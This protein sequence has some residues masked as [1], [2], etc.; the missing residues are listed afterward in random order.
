MKRKITALLAVLLCF[1]VNTATVCAVYAP[2]D[3]LSPEVIE[4]MVH[5]TD[6]ISVSIWYKDD[7]KPGLT[8]EEAEKLYAAMAEE[9]GLEPLSYHYGVNDPVIGTKLTPEQILKIAEDDQVTAITFDRIESAVAFPTAHPAESKMDDA[10]WEA[11]DSGQEELYVHIK[12][13]NADQTVISEQA[14]EDAEILRESLD[15]EKYTL[16][17]INTIVANFQLRKKR[18]GLQKYV[19]DTARQIAE[20][21]GLAEGSYTHGT[22]LPTLSATLTPEQVRQAEAMGIVVGMT[23]HVDQPEDFSVPPTE[24]VEGMDEQTP[25]PTDVDV[26]QDPTEPTTEL[27]GSEPV[28]GDF[29]HDG[30]VNASDAAVILIYSAKYGAGQFDGSFEE[31]VKG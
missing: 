10:L 9:F 1:A 7:G 13:L 4:E 19:A 21:L 8:A 17:Q 29:N 27:P 25:A 22:Y 15:P 16:S 23:L 6:L 24:M 3:K 18:I 28:Y 14:R 31:Y 12:F 20:E 30:V 2:E 11:L 5:A 26:P